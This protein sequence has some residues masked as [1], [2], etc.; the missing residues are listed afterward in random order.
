MAQTL[1]KKV[2]MSAFY[3]PKTKKPKIWVMVFFVLIPIALFFI[4]LNVGKSFVKK[5]AAEPKEEDTAE[6]LFN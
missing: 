3:D 6:N 5:K 2:N 4:G 1:D